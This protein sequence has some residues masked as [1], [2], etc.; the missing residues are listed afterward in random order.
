M[1]WAGAPPRFSPA[2]AV[3]WRV[4]ASVVGP[5]C[6]ASLVFA[7]HEVFAVRPLC[8]SR[9][10]GPLVLLAALAVVSAIS[11]LT[12]AAVN[13]ATG[14]VHQALRDLHVLG[15]LLRRLEGARFD[16]PLLGRQHEALKADGHRASE[17]IRRLDRLV[18][19]L[20]AR[21]NAMFAPFALAGLWGLQFAL[22]IDA[23]R[24]RAGPLIPGWLDAVG[25]LEALC[26]LSGYAY[27]HPDDAFPEFS[28]HGPAFAAEDLGHPLLPAAH[29]VRNDLS[30]DPPCRVFI[31]SGSNMSGKSTLL[32]SVGLA[33]VMARAGGPVRAR[34]LSLSPL[35]LG[36]SIRIND[37]LQQ[38]ASRFYAEIRRLSRVMDLTDGDRPLMFLLDEVLHGTNS[39]DRLQGATAL[40]RQFIARGAMGLVTTHDLALA[41]TTKELGDRVE[42]VHFCDSIV[43][44][45]LLFDYRLRPGVVQRSNAIELMRSVGLDV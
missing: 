19:W 21:Q 41:G 43:D 14:P 6:V 18:T 7:L 22:S 40:I 3:V 44:K 5:L 24:R 4:A 29:C 12:A 20:D 31:V 2:Q 36:A 17:T 39:H 1:S 33:V 30:F 26:A 42:N 28:D 37:S 10:T 35:R 32:R 34:R 38:G 9:A 45:E 11:R 15:G 23:W 25:R 16:A 8:D 13:A 27:E